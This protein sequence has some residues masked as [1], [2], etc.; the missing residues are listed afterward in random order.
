MMFNLGDDAG[1]PP[2]PRAG[3]ATPRH[4]VTSAV[5]V[6]LTKLS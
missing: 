1:I 3:A 5:T 6:A 4:G 2:G